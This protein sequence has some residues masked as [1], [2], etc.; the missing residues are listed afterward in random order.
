[1][2]HDSLPNAV[3][4]MTGDCQKDDGGLSDILC[5]LSEKRKVVSEV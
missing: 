1:M 3:R 2:S 5:A 4:R